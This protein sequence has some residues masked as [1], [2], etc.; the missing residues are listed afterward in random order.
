MSL[1]ASIASLPA[2]VIS[3]L[4]AVIPL[5]RVINIDDMLFSSRWT[6]IRSYRTP[7]HLA[8]S[9]SWLNEASQ[10]P[11]L[12]RDIL[13]ALGDLE[14]GR[15]VAPLVSV[16]L[17]NRLKAE[18]RRSWQKVDF[19]MLSR[20]VLADRNLPPPILDFQQFYERFSLSPNSPERCEDG[21][22]ALVRSMPDS[23]YIQSVVSVYCPDAIAQPR[24]LEL[25]LPYIPGSGLDIGDAAFLAGR[26]W[27]HLR[28][29]ASFNL[30]GKLM[31]LFR[32]TDLGRY[33]AAIKDDYGGH[34]GLI[35]LL[36]FLCTSHYRTRPNGPAVEIVMDLLKQEPKREYPCLAHLFGTIPQSSAFVSPFAANS[37]S[38]W[39]RRGWSY[40]EIYHLLRALPLFQYR[41]CK[42]NNSDRPTT[43]EHHRSL[44][45]ALGLLDDGDKLDIINLILDR[46]SILAIA[47]ACESEDP[48][49]RCIAGICTAIVCQVHRLVAEEA[50]FELGERL[51]ANFVSRTAK[52]GGRSLTWELRSHLEQWRLN[53]RD[54]HTAEWA[55]RCHKALLSLRPLCQKYES[56]RAH[57]DRIGFPADLEDIPETPPYNMW[58]FFEDERA[59]THSDPDAEPR[60][61]VYRV[62]EIFPAP[63]PPLR[64]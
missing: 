17:Q 8:K 52:E 25:L 42:W 16:E 46:L 1:M 54:A 13:F 35:E 27:R 59:T 20:Y 32:P 39:A 3:S 23:W 31:L 33:N 18:L 41:H 44:E 49:R 24:M 14:I 5:C 55:Q 64:S 43:S 56:L 29:N 2:S 53:Q 11:Q 61:V 60:R 62:L 57:W 47:E 7:E 48:S 15:Q 12:F 34:S 58:P 26:C 51:L 9:L 45:R 6:E 36:T 30:Y 40:E 10:D 4:R 50:T 22:A 28:D 37:L 19:H 21:L 63:S 38:I